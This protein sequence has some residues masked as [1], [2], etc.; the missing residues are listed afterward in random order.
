MISDEIEAAQL[1]LTGQSETPLID[2]RRLLCAA[3]GFSHGDLY[4]YPERQLSDKERAVFSDYIK[5]RAAGEPIAYILGRQAFWDM[6]LMVSSETL[7]PRPETELLVEKALDILD[8]AKPLRLL[9]LG[10]GSGTIALALA[11]ASPK[12]EIVAVDQEAGALN[13]AKANAKALSLKNVTFIQSNW[14]EALTSQRFHAIISNPPYIE[15]H[16]Q[17]LA[18]GDLRFE[19]KTALDGGSDGFA[20]IDV[21]LGMAPDYLYAGG[22]LMLEHGYNQ[23]AEVCMKLK[24]FG[25]KQI[26]QYQDLNQLDRVSIA[27]WP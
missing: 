12:W 25:Y 15:S 2:A 13:V 21:I 20:S 26:K 6:E 3:L 8:Q 10:A 11:K 17:H 4:A 24:G 5:R 16:D 14:F 23:G 9:D 1:S 22:W 7:I 27:Q 19:P 18:Q